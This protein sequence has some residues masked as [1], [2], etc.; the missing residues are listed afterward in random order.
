MENTLKYIELHKNNKVMKLEITDTSIL[1]NSLVK[2]LNLKAPN[3][4][5]IED[6]YTL[7]I[8]DDWQL[9]IHIGFE[10]IDDL[11]IKEYYISID[12]LDFTL[13]NDVYLI[14]ENVNYQLEK[15]K[16][17]DAYLLNKLVNKQEDQEEYELDIFDNVDMVVFAN[18]KHV[19]NYLNIYYRQL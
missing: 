18:Q 9:E 16:L 1:F 14:Y 10:M 3:I 17:T 8:K 13:K 15:I 6:Y 12:L 11:D 19:I 4:H 5:K 2:Q 7:D